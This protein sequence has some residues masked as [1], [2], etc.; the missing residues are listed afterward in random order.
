MTLA[1]V[2]LTV[3]VLVQAFATTGR[4]A[5]AVVPAAPQPALLAIAFA[6]PVAMALATGVEAPSSAIA[7]LGQLDDDGRRH[8]ARVTLW[9]TLG[10]VG[11]LTIGLAAAARHLNIGIPEE[12]TRRSPRSPAPPPGQ[13]SSP[14]FRPR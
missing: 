6:F 7:Q 8:F 10:V 3:V 13:P 5:E 4:V 11:A 2:G 12:D 9:L 1:F 14:P